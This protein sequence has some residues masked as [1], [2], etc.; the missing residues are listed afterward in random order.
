M[1]PYAIAKLLQSRKKLE[2]ELA[3]M[4]QEPKIVKAVTRPNASR[5]GGSWKQH[6]VCTL[7]AINNIDKILALHGV[8]LPKPKDWSNP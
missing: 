7:S 2:D 8:K 3:A 4:G 6:V 1:T 5:R